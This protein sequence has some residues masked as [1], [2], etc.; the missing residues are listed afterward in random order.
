MQ[1]IIAR[2]VHQWLRTGR[3]FYNNWQSFIGIELLFKLLSIAVFTPG[4]AYFF[5]SVLKSSG[6]TA[7]SNYDLISFFLS[8][9]GILIILGFATSGFAI[10]FFEIG[11]LALVAIAMRRRYKISALRTLHFLFTRLPALF[12]LGIRQFLAVAAVVL[13]ATSVA[14]VAKVIFLSG[15]DIYFYM[16]V[17]PPEFWVT[18]V[19]SSISFLIA[20][21]AIIYLLVR[22]IFSV[23]VMLIA[24]VRPNEAMK[25]SWSRVRETGYWPITQKLV[26]W[27]LGIVIVVGLGSLVDAVVSKVL[28]GLAGDQINLVITSAGLLLAFGFLLGL[29]ISFFIVVSLAITIS[30]LFITW[31]P[32]AD[33]P[34]SLISG[35][36]QFSKARKFRMGSLL[37]SLIIAF[38]CLSL[39]FAY[40][41][42]NQVE[43]ENTVAV[44]AHRG[45]SARAPENTM[46]AIELAIQDG[47]DFAEIDVQETADGVVVLFHDTDLRRMAG[48]NKGIWDISYKEMS[49]LDIGSWFSEKF[50]DTRVATLEEVIRAVKGKMKLNI[51]LKFNGHSQNLESEVVRLVREAQFEDE[52]IITS[53]HASGVRNVAN[54]DKDLRRGL[55]V[56]ANIGDLTSLDVDILAVNANA[57]TRDLVTR[58]HRADMEV[59]VWT[60]NDPNQMLTMIHMGVDNIMTDS[61]EL[62]VELI[63]TRSK[64]GRIEKALLFISDF[65]SG[66]L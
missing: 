44:T 56:T 22:W 31:N 35:K 8:P 16:N 41:L 10:L 50:S 59:H 12:E 14:L 61:P 25:M 27:L 19:V 65:L 21:C 36:G 30:D 1:R 62:L 17:K 5:N 47:A 48:V 60:V 13:V 2:I 52:C 23:P 4:W 39:F 57:V 6:D 33:I 51:E 45:S 53:L 24:N 40:N 63:E 3:E 49:E 64:M 54:V 26:I 43:I 42:I 58:A 37:T 66:R 32:E 20:G 29:F 18:L 11:G 46:P 28:L 38:L 55:I 9:Q 15:G 34:E 7:V